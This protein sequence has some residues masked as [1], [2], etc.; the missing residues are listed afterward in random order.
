MRKI[1]LVKFLTFY[2]MMYPIR[3]KRNL[4]HNGIDIMIN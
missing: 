3:Q 1:I 4:Q 2:T